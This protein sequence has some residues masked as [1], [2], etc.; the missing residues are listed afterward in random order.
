LNNINVCY[1]V[2]GQI[3][4]YPVKIS[5]VEISYKLTSQI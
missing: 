3:L 1:E 2:I 5:V 4:I